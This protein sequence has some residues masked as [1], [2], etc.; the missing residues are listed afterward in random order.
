MWAVTAFT[1]PALSLPHLCPCHTYS[2]SHI[3]SLYPPSPPP[4]L[5]S[6]LP[7]TPAFPAAH[8]TPYP[9]SLKATLCGHGP[10]AP[11][12]LPEVLN[13]SQAVASLQPQGKSPCPQDPLLGL[14]SLGQADKAQ[15]PRPLPDSWPQP[16]S[17]QGRS[18]AIPQAAKHD[19]GRSF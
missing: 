12:E 13:S 8:H 1:R 4:I 2:D 3:H 18:W 16:S 9:P 6:P 11:S 10:W 7:A 19:F 14:V 15:W 17:A 5:H